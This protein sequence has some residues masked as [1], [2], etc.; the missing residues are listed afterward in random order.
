MFWATAARS[1]GD[2][3]FEK[4]K[5]QSKTMG[6][7]SAF[8]EKYV[9]DCAPKIAGGAECEQNAQAFR[10]SATGK[11]F[12]LMVPEATGR[13]LQMGSSESDG[14][15]TLNMVPFLSTAGS[16]ITH[17]APSKTD[18]AGNPIMPF[19]RIEGQLPTAWNA[20]MMARQV[21]SQALRLEIILTPQGLWSLPKRGGGAIKGV[22]ARFEA[23]RV[24]VARTGEQVG[25]WVAK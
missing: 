11:K 23:I 3:R 4:L 9:G 19:I 1:E 22:N 21:A 24:S 2:D 14:S 17:G 25:L 16:A 13:T 5:A 6:A 7:A 8:T 20:G 12:F 10:Q 18:A 15:F